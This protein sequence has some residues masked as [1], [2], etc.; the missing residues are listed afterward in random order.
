MK[1]NFKQNGVFYLFLFAFLVLLFSVTSKNKSSDWSLSLL[2]DDQKP[3]GTFLF[4]TLMKHRFNDK[5]MQSDQ[6]LFQI[7]SSSIKSK[8]VILI[9][10]NLEIK[11]DDISEIKESVKNGDR[12]IIAANNINQAVCDSFNISMQSIVLNKPFW[13]KDEKSNQKSILRMLNRN[14]MAIDSV[15]IDDGMLRSYFFNIPTNGRV[16]IENEGLVVSFQLQEGSGVVDFCSTPFLFTNY[17]LMPNSK[18]TSHLLSGIQKEKVIFASR[19]LLLKKSSDSIFKNIYQNTA[20]RSIF[21]LLVVLILLFFLF[22]SKRNQRVIP[23]VTPLS[24]ASLEFVKLIG[25]SY[26]LKSNHTDLCLKKASYL[27][28]HL[29]QNYFIR[30]S[31]ENSEQVYQVIA[32]KTNFDIESVRSLFHRLD[33]ISKSKIQISEK[34]LHHLIKLMEQYY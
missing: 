25:R 27:K 31:D 18:A 11:P 17:F 29:S 26:F 33:Q 6:T 24:N 15:Y 5:Y 10:D 22:G 34:E 1:S 3:F 23:V 32:S 8:T 20:L 14:Q 9:A 30:F 28:D 4:D 16:T 7:N 12:Y 2:P 21:I 13:E 19:Y